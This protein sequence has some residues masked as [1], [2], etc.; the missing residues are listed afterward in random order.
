ML[1]DRRGVCQG[2]AHLTVGALRTIGLAA[3]YVS[4]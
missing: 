1:G 4:G 2:F 3:R